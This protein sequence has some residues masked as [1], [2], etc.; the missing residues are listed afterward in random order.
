MKSQRK[1]Q[2]GVIGSNEASEEQKQ[3]AYQIGCY[4]AANDAIL[5]NG[6]RLGVME[7]ASHGAS[8]KKGLVIGILPQN[9]TQT[10]KYLD[11]QI[12]TQMGHGRNNIIVQSSDLLIAIG[13]GFGTLSEIA[14]GLKSNKTVLGIC[15]W[16]IPGI[17][18]FHTIEDLK[19]QIDKEISIFLS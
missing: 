15:T 6:G 14:L 9:A 4:I 7:A 13:K 10:N 2:V 8:E 5:I 12:Q 11:V 18:L 3:L 1:M 16:S 19:I 17:K